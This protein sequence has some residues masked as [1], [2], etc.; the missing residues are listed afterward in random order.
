[1]IK[2]IIFDC[3]GVLYGGSLSTLTSMC[4]PERYE[5]LRSLNKQADYG[6][7]SGEDYIQGLSEVLGMSYGDV[8]QVMARKHHRNEELVEFVRALRAGGAY[9]I[10]LLSNVGSG[11]V[12]QLFGDDLR[13]LFDSVVLSYQESLAKPNPGIYALAAERMGL[14]ASECVMIDDLEPNCDGAE[15]A[16]MQSIL[17]ITNDTTRRELARILK[18]GA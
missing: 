2:G 13:Q 14:S 1:M 12:E 5:E 15:I 7:I 6:F 18:E 17:H 16:G 3:F 11:T 8:A 10:G 9:K 4:P